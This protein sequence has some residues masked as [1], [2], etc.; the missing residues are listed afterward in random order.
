MIFVRSI[1]TI[2]KDRTAESLTKVPA[3]NVVIAFRSGF[4]ANN[5]YPDFYNIRD[6]PNKSLDDQS[7]CIEI[8]KRNYRGVSGDRGINVLA[9]LVKISN[10]RHYNGP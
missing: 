4:K 6:G 7:G 2:V 1:A 10:R 9:Q 8:Q 5:Y 3:K